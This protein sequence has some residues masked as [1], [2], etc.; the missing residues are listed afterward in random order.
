VRP[1]VGDVG[2][3]R[4]RHGIV[5]CG[6][7][8]GR[9]ENGAAVVD[10]ELDIGKALGILRQVHNSSGSRNE[11]RKAV[12]ARRLNNGLCPPPSNTAPSAGVKTRVDSTARIPKASMIATVTSVPSMFACTC[13]SPISIVSV[14][15]LDRSDSC[16]S[17]G[18]AKRLEV[19]PA[20]GQQ[21]VN[22]AFEV[23]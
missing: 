7:A 8:A 5:N 11:Y 2:I 20:G 12:S 19:H 1:F 9:V 4:H 16:G 10:D 6:L 21:V 17:V 15:R 18:S 13:A 22:A 23:A 14:A 3:A